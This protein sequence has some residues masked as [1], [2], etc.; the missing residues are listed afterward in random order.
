VGER[1]PDTVEVVGSIPSAPTIYPIPNIF[2]SSI[3][4][5]HTYHHIST[6]LLSSGTIVPHPFVA[7]L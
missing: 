6:Y 1:Y 4:N 2:H 7:S 3:F 5:W